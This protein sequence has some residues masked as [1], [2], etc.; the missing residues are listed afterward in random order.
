MWTPSPPSTEKGK[1]RE[2]L[3]GEP[4]TPERWKTNLKKKPKPKKIIK[5]FPPIFF[6]GKGFLEPKGNYLIWKN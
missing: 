3:Q 6:L 2:G 1:P 4:Q 5:S